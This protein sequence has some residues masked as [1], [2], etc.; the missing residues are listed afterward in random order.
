M[1]NQRAM[2][3]ASPFAAFNECPHLAP[4]GG[5]GARACD[6]VNWDTAKAAGIGAG[7]G[8]LLG[9][10]HSEEHW[11]SPLSLQLQPGPHGELGLGLRIRF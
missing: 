7:L 9:S 8:L 6:G 1:R 5:A 3:V 2:A 11:G 10:L 4:A